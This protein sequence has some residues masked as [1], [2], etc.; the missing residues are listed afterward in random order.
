ME[1]PVL[2]H[3]SIGI[4]SEGGNLFEHRDPA[5]CWKQRRQGYGSIS[6]G[7]SWG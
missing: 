3:P 7:G 5:R 6:K 2:L 1:N 4:P